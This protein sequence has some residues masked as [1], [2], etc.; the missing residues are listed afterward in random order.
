MNKPDKKYFNAPDISPIRNLDI[1]ESSSF[2]RFFKWRTRRRKWI[3]NEDWIVY[4]EYL[5][6]WVKIPKGFVFDGASVPKTFQS[7]VSSVDALFYGS[8]LHDF[9]YRTNQLIVCHDSNFGSWR[10]KYSIGKVE[11]DRI[12]FNFN[13]QAENL[14][15]PNTIGYY[16]LVVGGLFTWNKARKAG[17]TLNT[18]YPHAENFVLHKGFANGPTND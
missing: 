12:L 1:L 7:V 3:F 4:V 18:A 5:E 13:I 9:I 11:A 14:V 2:S 16:T 6:C 8:I 17:L 15:T 10:L